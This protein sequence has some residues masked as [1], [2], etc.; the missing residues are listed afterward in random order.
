M[1]QSPDTPEVGLYIVADGM[2]GHQSGEVASKDVVRAVVEHI[3]E[4]LN[5]LQAAPKVKRAT[6]RLEHMTTPGEVLQQAIQRANQ[7]L[8]TAKRSI[9]SNRGTTIT[10]ALVVG[11]SCSI[12]NVGDSRTYLFHNEELCQITRDHSLVASMLAAGMIKPEEVRSHPQRNQILRQLGDK[13][14]VEVDIF[15]A[16]LA[17]GDK[18]ILCS[19]GLWEMVLDEEIQNLVAQSPTAQAA[20]DRLV[21]LANRAGGEDNISV[22]VIS[23]E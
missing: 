19:D 13:P 14:N 21:E 8:Y 23:I 10:A 3:Q 15:S 17:A 20:S 5:I 7:I 16:M 2:G 6:V 9:G 12:A 22:M 11:D 18:L 4:N 1:V